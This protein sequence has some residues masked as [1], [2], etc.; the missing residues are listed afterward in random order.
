MVE[1]P[2]PSASRT[3]ATYI[4][5]CLSVCSRVNSFASFWPHLNFTP[6]LIYHAS[7]ARASALLTCRMAA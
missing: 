3:A 7:T 1:Q 5:H 4:R 6:F 2:N